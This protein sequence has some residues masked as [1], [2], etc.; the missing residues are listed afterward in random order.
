[1]GQ[2]RLVLSNVSKKFNDKVLFNNIDLKLD[3]GHYVLVGENGCGKTT[4]LKTMMGLILPDDGNVKLLGEDTKIFSNKT[5]AKI[6]FAFAS[7]RTLYHKLTAYENLKYIGNI[8]GLKRSELNERIPALLNKVGLANNNQYIETY[9]TGMKKRLMFI[10]AILNNPEVI[11]LDEIYS[12]LDEDGCDVVNQII[13][14]EIK[15][16]KLIISVTHQQDKLVQ[17]ENIYELKE[18][19]LNVLDCKKRADNEYQI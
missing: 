9:S 3:K 15:N 6:G 1:M 7:D 4:L 19:K 16:D 11:F 14:D 10:K 5:K 8:Y 18:G 12:G 13:D 17:K 2:S